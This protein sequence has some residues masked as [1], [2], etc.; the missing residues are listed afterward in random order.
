[1]KFL[2]IIEFL[3]NCPVS[4]LC[5]NSL[6]AVGKVIFKLTFVIYSAFSFI[7]CN[8][9]ITS[10]HLYFLTVT[11]HKDPVVF[12]SEVPTSL[13]VK[14][15]WPNFY[16]FFF[17]FQTTIHREINT[18][19][20]TWDEQLCVNSQR[21][22]HSGTFR[23][24]TPSTPLPPPPLHDPPLPFNP[25]PLDNRS[26]PSPVYATVNKLPHDKRNLPLLLNSSFRSSTLSKDRKKSVTIED[27]NT[28]IKKD[29]M[30]VSSKAKK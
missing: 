1:M 6:T 30:Y 21:S 27:T 4:S 25:Q 14:G 23:P 15:L 22:H 26:T 20:Q 5:E 10:F 17:N 29:P 13:Y 8:I 19:L 18:A 11:F 7:N 28:I 12:L 24:S 16:N 3:L 9:N 2:S